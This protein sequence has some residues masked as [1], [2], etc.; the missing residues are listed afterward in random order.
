MTD[1]LPNDPKD[2]RNKD[3]QLVDDVKSLPEEEKKEMMASLEMYEGPIP[4][5]KILEGYEHLYK[6]AAKKI[7]DNGIEESNHRRY[8]ENKRQRRRGRLAY[9][10][11]VGSFIIIVILMILSFLLIMNNHPII[12]SIFGGISVLSVIG[13]AFDKVDSLSSNDDFKS[14]N[15]DK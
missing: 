7:I 4:H 13:N 9:I 15:D 5:P 2:I 14:N 12:G 3:Q 11:L 6:G 10:D 8:M 1:Q